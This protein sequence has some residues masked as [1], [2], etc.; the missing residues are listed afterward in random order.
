MSICPEY[1]RKSMMSRVETFEVD[2][3]GYGAT[4]VNTGDRRTSRA[5][6]LIAAAAVAMACVAL[7][8]A[9]GSLSQRSGAVEME[10]VSMK[11]ID[12]LLDH[13]NKL[14]RSAR[15][16][17][18]A[19]GAASGKSGVLSVKHGD[20]LGDK[21]LQEAMAAE[22]SLDT[23]DGQQAPTKTQVKKQKMTMKSMQALEDQIKG[24]FAKVT[25]FGDKAGFL[26]PVKVPHM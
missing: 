17:K 14:T 13:I 1:R 24:D 20:H 3:E 21:A 23:S 5:R 6:Q 25:G 22:S 12:G 16:G 26:P 8:A 11:T 18:S 9:S 4:V 2:G 7:L 10:G 19:D 15:T